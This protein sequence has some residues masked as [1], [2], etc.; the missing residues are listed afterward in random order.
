MY[1]ISNY[2][3]IQKQKYIIVNTIIINKTNMPGC[4]STFI[5]HCMEYKDKSKDKIICVLPCY[6]PSK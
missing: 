2:T 6:V 3:L 4:H 1:V 5:G